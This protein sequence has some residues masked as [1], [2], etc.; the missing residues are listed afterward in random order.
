MLDRIL[1]EPLLSLIHKQKDNSGKAL[2]K[3]CDD[4]NEAFNNNENEAEKKKKEADS[5][6]SDHNT[7]E[8]KSL[9]TLREGLKENNFNIS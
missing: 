5:I 2:S 6:I 4:Y 9:I 1:A 7:D 3:I 8:I